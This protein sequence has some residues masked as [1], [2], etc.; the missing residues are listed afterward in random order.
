MGRGKVSLLLVTE[1]EGIERC[2]N[3]WMNMKHKEEGKQE[4]VRQEHNKVGTQDSG[5]NC[6]LLRTEFSNSIWNVVN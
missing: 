3:G 5:P 4:S 1:Q 6:K 2:Q